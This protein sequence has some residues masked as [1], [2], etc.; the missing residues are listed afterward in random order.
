MT[1]TAAERNRFLETYAAREKALASG[2]GAWLAPVRSSAIHRF[3]EM[4]LPTTRLEDWRYTS[5][6]PIADAEFVLPDA[7]EP[8]GLTPA[9]LQPLTSPL[10]DAHLLV[11]VNGHFAEDLSMTEDLPE[12][13]RVVT[14]AEALASHRGEIEPHLARLAHYEDQAFTALNTALMQDGA[15]I[16]VPAGAVV[17]DPIHLLYVSTPSAKGSRMTCPRNL[18]VAGTGSQATVVET[19]AGLGPDRSFTNAVTEIAA[20]DNSVLD[21]YKIQDE[22]AGALHVGAATARLGRSSVLTSHVVSLGSALC[23]NDLRVLFGAEGGDCTLNGLYLASGRQ[24]VDNHTVIDHAT[25]HCSSREIYKGVLSGKARG[26]FDGKVIVRPGAQKT[27]SRQVNNNLLLSDDALV[28]TKPQLEINADDVKCAHAATIGQLDTD[29]LFYMR[30]RAIDLMEARG[31]LIRGFVNDML[32]RI[33]I[34][35]LRAALERTLDKRL[36]DGAAGG[37]AS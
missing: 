28:D 7:Y 32:D 5:V 15:C 26:V 34:Q 1:N 29:A 36:G 11:F 3:G 12:G 31:M 22:G 14:L 35:S 10:G 33:R 19:Y 20:G 25:P 21:H 18:V 4:G 9:K 6:K 24:H 2:P 13:V 17:R 23:R 16:L 37:G 8:D 30:A 27:D